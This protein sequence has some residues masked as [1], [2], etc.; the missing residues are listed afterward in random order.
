MKV[1]PRV[2]ISFIVGVVC[3]FC[4][5]LLRLSA[6]ALAWP[7]YH[8]YSGPRESTIWAIRERAYEHIALIILIFGLAL[9]L[10]TCH[11]WLADTE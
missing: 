8:G 7:S 5:V 10:V 9:I 1:K 11:R 3:T 2:M 4:G 6:N